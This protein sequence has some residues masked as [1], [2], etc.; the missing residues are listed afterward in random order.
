VITSFLDTFVFAC[1][2]EPTEQDVV[3]LIGS[4]VKWR[5]FQ[6]N[7]WM[8]VFVSEQAAEC[9]AKA[10]CGFPPWALVQRAVVKMDLGLAP[11]DVFSL[12]SGF[13]DRLPTI[14]ETIGVRDVLI[15]GAQCAPPLRTRRNA[16]FEAD[17]ERLLALI[18]LFEQLGH[19]D[20][21]NKRSILSRNLDACPTTVEF[22]AVL[23][24]SEP[25][26]PGPHPLELRISA[27]V[28]GCPTRYLADIDP[29]DIWSE[30][31]SEE[32]LVAAIRMYT[33]RAAQLSGINEFNTWIVGPKFRSTIETLHLRRK[34]MARPI[35]RACA[36]TILNQ[37]L[38][39]THALRTNESGSSQQLRRGNNYALRR[40]IDHEFHLHYWSTP[41]HVEFASIVI[42]NDFSI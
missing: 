5:A 3:E 39:A 26:I 21:Q 41:N 27:K 30:A 35:L 6:K 22:S 37:H 2:N 13:L 42:H 8:R 31:T 23:H 38:A 16:V 29:V 20:G 1:P 33:K 32:E 17:F 28:F 12:M 25:N 11:H 36:E 9:L 14:E 10:G 7:E 40:D 4:L 15:D 24:E 34:H 18:C 19:S